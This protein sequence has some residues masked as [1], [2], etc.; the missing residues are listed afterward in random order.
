M[1][2]DIKKYQRKKWD[3]FYELAL[4]NGLHAELDKMGEVMQRLLQERD[5]FKKR[6]EEAQAKARL[7]YEQWRLP[8]ES[9][10]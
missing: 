6:F 5:A 1:A 3:T 10:E 8:E 4:K 9:E 7:A 2:G